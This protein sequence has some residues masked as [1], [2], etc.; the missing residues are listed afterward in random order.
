MTEVTPADG[1]ARQIHSMTATTFWS[2]DG[3]P[4]SAEQFLETLYGV[5]YEFFKDEDELRTLWSLPDTR[6]KLLEGLAEKG[7]SRE[8]LDRCVIAF[9]V[10]AALVKWVS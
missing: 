2:A 7:F 3:R 10:I 8:P 5:L 9:I 1:K 4:M 6:R